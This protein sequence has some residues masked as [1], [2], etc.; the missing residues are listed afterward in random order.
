MMGDD[1]EYYIEQQQEEADYHQQMVYAREAEQ[2]KSLFC[3]TD[4]DGYS[5]DLWNWK[6]LSRVENVFL[7][8]HDS[9]QLGSEYFLADDDN[10]S[11]S[12][13]SSNIKLTNGLQFNIAT[14]KNQA[15]YEVIVLSPQDASQLEIEAITQKEAA[16]SLKETMISEMLVEMA[17]FINKNKV[18]KSFVFF[19]EL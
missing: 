11:G 17:S 6:P 19:R 7:S 2:T 14:D 12:V 3:W 8:L 5:D 13:Q 10:V 16:S 18:K 15:V 9:R 4:E 1:A